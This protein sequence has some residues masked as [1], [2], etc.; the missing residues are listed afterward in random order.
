MRCLRGFLVGLSGF[1]IGIK[2]GGNASK[3]IS[4]EAVFLTLKD[5]DLL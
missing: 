3:L 4:Y 1:I 5:A 2:R